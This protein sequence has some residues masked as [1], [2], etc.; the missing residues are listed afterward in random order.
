MT[1][2]A[3]PPHLTLMFVVVVMLFLA[4]RQTLEEYYSTGILRAQGVD[5]P[6]LPPHVFQVADTAF[7][8]M[9]AGAT[10]AAAEASGGGSGNAPVAA[11]RNQ[12]ML[13]SGES[14]AGKTETTKFMMQV[15]LNR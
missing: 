10:A 13:V 14:G 11:P 6:P 5:A 4:P 9:M 7:R 8:R 15:R 12:S 2:G 3:V 1:Y